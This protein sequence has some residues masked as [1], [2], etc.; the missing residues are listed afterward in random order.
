MN[1]EYTNTLE[2]LNI[3][4]RNEISE[5]K[6]LKEGETVYYVLKTHYSL[7]DPTVE[8]R[9][10]QDRYD[11]SEVLYGKSSAY[12]KTFQEYELGLLISTMYEYL[13]NKE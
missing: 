6:K 9:K 3:K 1:F 8:I 11:L 10:R 12:Y 5:I 13:Y 2:N 7:I 4:Y